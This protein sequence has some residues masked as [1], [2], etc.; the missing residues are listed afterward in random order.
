MCLPSLARCFKLLTFPLFQALF[1]LNLLDYLLGWA[2]KNTKFTKVQVHFLGA[3]FCYKTGQKMNFLAKMLAWEWSGAIYNIYISLS[4]YS[5]SLSISL[6]IHLSL[7]PFFLSLLFSLSLYSL[8]IVSL[9]SLYCLS[10]FSLLSRVLFVGLK[11]AFLFIRIVR[12][13]FFSSGLQ[14]GVFGAPRMGRFRFQN[15]KIGRNRPYFRPQTPPVAKR[16]WI[17]LPGVASRAAPREWKKGWVSLPSTVMSATWFLQER[18]YHNCGGTMPGCL[19][20][21]PCDTL[22]IGSPFGRPLAEEDSQAGSS[23]Y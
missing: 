22:L 1:T 23:C 7:F 8:S 9:L 4:F 19:K 12:R 18:S 11:K 14:K 21:F 5:I 15:L 20:R 17:A 16:L 13:H 3:I 6:S 2:Q 10:L